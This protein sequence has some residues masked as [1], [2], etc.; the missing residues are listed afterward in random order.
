M[1]SNP[2]FYITRDIE[3]VLGIEPSQRYFVVANNGEYARSI[4]EKY[5]DFV[6]IVE[7]P[8]P[9]DTFEILEQEKTSVFLEKIFGK[10]KPTIVV[11]KNTVRIEEFCVKKGWL[12]LNPPSS[13]AEKIE[14]KIT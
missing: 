14:N 9:L 2:I 13:L 1:A 12:L 4:K 6:M 3:R 11:F 5:P 8:L 10:E 7:S